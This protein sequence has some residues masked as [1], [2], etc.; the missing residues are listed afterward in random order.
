MVFINGICP[1][2]RFEC[3]VEKYMQLTFPLG[4]AMFLDSGC[5]TTK[6]FAL[7]STLI[8]RWQWSQAR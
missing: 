3:M 4:I 7:S 8:D 1:I 6:R 2:Y 5:Q